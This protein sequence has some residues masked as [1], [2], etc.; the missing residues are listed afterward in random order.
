MLANVLTKHDTMCP[1]LSLF[2][3]TGWVD[4]TQNRILC[5]VVR[6]RLEYTEADLVNLSLDDLEL[7]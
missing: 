2:L 7:Q 3:Q 4:Y 5:R 6:R 1:I